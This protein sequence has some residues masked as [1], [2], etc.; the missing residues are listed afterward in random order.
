MRMGVVWA[1]MRII[2]NIRVNNNNNN[3]VEAWIIDWY[4]LLQLQ[5]FLAVIIWFE[6]E[7]DSG[8]SHKGQTHLKMTTRARAI[9]LNIRSSIYYA[10]GG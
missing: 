1:A 9:H 5:A 3:R 4:N 8:K 6:V 10:K 7:L 2:L